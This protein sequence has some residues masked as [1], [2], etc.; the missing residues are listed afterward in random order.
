[1][2]ELLEFSICL[3]G[4]CREHDVPAARTVPIPSK[5]NDPKTLHSSLSTPDALTAC[6]L[7]QLA[8]LKLHKSD[9]TFS[10]K[11]RR[12]FRDCSCVSVRG[13]V[14]PARIDSIVFVIYKS[15]S[16]I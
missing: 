13:V 16:C 7:F 6:R 4:M 5:S 8:S 1:M 2:L 14:G 11:A 10:A 12:C 9:K 3:P 15:V